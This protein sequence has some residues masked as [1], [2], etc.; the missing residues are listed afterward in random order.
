MTESQYST[1]QI[2]KD[3][4]MATYDSY[5][6]IIDADP[7]ELVGT[8]SCSILNSAGASSSDDLTIQGLLQAFLYNYSR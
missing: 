3:G 5:F 2:L 4:E 7:K 6:D 1:Y 8:Y